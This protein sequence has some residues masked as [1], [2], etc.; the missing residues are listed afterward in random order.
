ML[1]INITKGNITDCED[2]E[3]DITEF[4]KAN[5]NKVLDKFNKSAKK[6]S[7]ATEDIKMCD[8]NDKE[9]SKLNPPI[10]PPHK[11]LVNIVVDH[12]PKIVQ[13]PLNMY[14]I[15]LEMCHML[16]IIW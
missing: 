7:K 2:Y 8:V 13:Q 4:A 12:Q 15:K 14:L 10:K 9:S 5:G 11:I 16:C 1:S 6:N 3:E